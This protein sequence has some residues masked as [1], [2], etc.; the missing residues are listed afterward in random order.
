MYEETNYHQS[1]G[2]YS[3]Q[4]P[5]VA[6]TG[7]ATAALVFGILAFIT[8]FFLINYLFGALAIIF[9][10]IYLVQKADVK[11]KGKAITG[12]VL[13]LI[14]MVISTI[15]F[16][17]IVFY[18]ANTEL[19]DMMEDIAWLMGEEIDGREIVEQMVFEATGGAIDLE[20]LEEFV[21]GE[22]TIERVVNFTGDVTEEEMYNFMEMVQQLDY[23]SLASE[24]PNG[25]TYE[26][27]E[28][29]L[30]VDFNLRELMEYVQA[31]TTTLP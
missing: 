2:Y 30:G 27:L 26:A 12:L 15:L 20:T 9:A 14:S 23:S 21:G 16:I 4:E 31:H 3:Y 18:F 10:I 6:K 5:V 11:P 7:F 25:I 28:E 22:I 29:K 24:F 8:T 17:S 1:Q 13:A 19:T